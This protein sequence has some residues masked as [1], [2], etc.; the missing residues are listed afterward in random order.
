MLIRHT[1]C[2]KPTLG[3]GSGGEGGT[4]LVLEFLERFLLLGG[5]SWWEGNVGQELGRK[6]RWGSYH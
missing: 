6:P 3:L 2:F 4:V 5:R 1:H